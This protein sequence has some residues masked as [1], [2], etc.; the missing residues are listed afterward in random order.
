MKRAF[1]CVFIQ[2]FLNL[3]ISFLSWRPFLFGEA[4][5]HTS[6]E[7]VHYQDQHQHSGQ[8]NFLSTIIQEQ[9]IFKHTSSLP[10][11]S[12]YTYFLW[13]KCDIWYKGNCELVICVSIYVC[14]IQYMRIRFLFSVLIHKNFPL[15]SHNNPSFSKLFINR[16]NSSE[17][18]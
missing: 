6:L 15:I 2:L 10:L 17:I 12:Q 4:N 9:E 13:Y 14:I 1:A 5:T 3:L 8:R 11:Y 7:E 18:N 16:L